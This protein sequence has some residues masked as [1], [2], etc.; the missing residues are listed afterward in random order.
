MSNLPPDVSGTEDH[1]GPRKEQDG[2]TYCHQCDQTTDHVWQ[3]WN[4]SVTR[5]SSSAKPIQT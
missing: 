5:S 1:F 4:N 2:T 3:R